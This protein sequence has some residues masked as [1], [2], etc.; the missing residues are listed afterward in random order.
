M[1]ARGCPWGPNG[2]FEPDSGTPKMGDSSYLWDKG[3]PWGPFWGSILAIIPQRTIPTRARACNDCAK[4]RVLLKTRSSR[5]ILGPQNVPIL[6]SSRSAWIDTDTHCTR[7]PLY[8]L[9]VQ[10]YVI[11]YP[12]MSPFWVFGTYRWTWIRVRVQIGWIWWITG[13][14]VM[15]TGWNGGVWGSQRMT[16]MS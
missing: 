4:E 9:Y 13:R 6:G 5:G 2:V 12:K 1:M 7:R 15:V 11:I 14:N 8:S 10:I 16:R 3:Y